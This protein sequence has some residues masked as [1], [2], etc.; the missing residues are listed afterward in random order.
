MR[1]TKM[2]GLGNDY[3]YFDVRENNNLHLTTEIIAKICDRHFGVGSD[4]VVLIQ[5]S[6]VADCFMRIYNKD[7][8]EAEMCGNALRCVARLLNDNGCGPNIKIDTLAGIRYAKVGENGIIE[9]NMGTPI[10]KEKIL[11]SKDFPFDGYSISVGNPHFV[12]FSN[13]LDVDFEKYAKTISENTKVF[14][15]KTNVEFVKVLDDNTLSVRVFERGSSE[16]LACGTG[17]TAV[18]FVANMLKIIGENATVKLKG[19][20]LVFA[21]NSKKEILMRGDAN[22]NFLGEIN[23]NGTN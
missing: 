5:K 22:Y 14:S 9:V 18:F 20:E 1:F 6:H 4:G 21:L 17:A 8:S 7:G 11:S 3:V 12:I 23:L 19:G 15:N 16:T 2:N 10:F 13:N